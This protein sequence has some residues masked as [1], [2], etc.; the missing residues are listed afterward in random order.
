MYG[1]RAIYPG[2][3]FPLLMMSPGFLRPSSLDDCLGGSPVCCSAFHTE[4]FSESSLMYWMVLFLKLHLV[5]VLLV[6]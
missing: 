2:F 4:A 6:P 1:L 5:Y 3:T